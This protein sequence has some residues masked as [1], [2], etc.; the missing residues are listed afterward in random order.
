VSFYRSKEQ[1]S[2]FAAT[3]SVAQVAAIIGV[4]T[5]AVI[6]AMAARSRPGAT[7]STQVEFSAAEILLR[8]FQDN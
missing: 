4:P 3:Q 5:S 8:V 1:A 6:E 2:P 7:A